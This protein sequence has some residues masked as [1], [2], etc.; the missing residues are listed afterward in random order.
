MSSRT[1]Y[2]QTETAIC[3]SHKQLLRAGFEFSQGCPAITP[4]VQSNDGV[5]ISPTSTEWFW[6]NATHIYIQLSGWDDNG[7]EITRFD[8]EYK[9]YGSKTWRKAE[10]RLPSIDQAWSH[11]VPSSILAQPNSFVLAELVPAQWYHVRV[12]AENAAGISTSMYSYATT[13]VQGESVGPP[14]D[15]FDLNMLVIICSS[16][17]LM[18]CS[19]TCVYILVKRHNHQHLTEYRNSLT[20]E[21]KSERSNMTVNTPQSV[22]SDMNNRVYSTPVHLT[23]ENKH[24]LYEISPYAQFAIGFRTFGHVDNQEV[25]NRVHLPG[26][27]KSRYDSETSFQMRSES[28]ESDCV[29]RTTT[30]KSVPRKA[31]RVPHHSHCRH[32]WTPETPEALQVRCRSFGGLGLLGIAKIWK[33]SNWASSNLTY[34]TKHKRC[35]TSGVSL[36]PY[37]GHYSRLR[38]TTEKFSKNRKKP[39]NTLPESNPR[40][41]LKRNY[42]VHAVILKVRVHKPASYAPHAQALTTESINTDRTDRIISNAY[43]VM[44]TDVIR[45]AYDASLWTFTL[46]SSSVS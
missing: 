1:R 34:T 11:Y 25:P 3:G 40:P 12:T 6:S 21:C 7:C 45:N 39:S 17:L 44:P 20:A 8:V 42:Y 24:E 23:A 46:I 5:P 37:T 30:L 31:C 43:H 2:T 26:N 15:F 19:L 29:S 36:F 27:S 10:N 38:A 16:I 22:P 14:S 32:P 35:F 28:E 41:L 33:G 4:T 9:E 13:T 18:I